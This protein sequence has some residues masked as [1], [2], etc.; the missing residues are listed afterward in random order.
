V[1]DE[2]E[3]L[4]RLRLLVDSGPDGPAAPGATRSVLS[5]DVYVFIPTA[6]PAAAAAGSSSRPEQDSD[7]PFHP[8]AQPRSSPAAAAAR[9]GGGG[10]MPEPV[11]AEEAARAVSDLIRRLGVCTP[12]LL[13]KPLC[14][15]TLPC[16]HTLSVTCHLCPLPSPFLWRNLSVVIFMIRFAPACPRMCTLIRWWGIV[17]TA[18]CV[19]G[20]RTA[21]CHHFISQEPP[22][23]WHSWFLL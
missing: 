7:S 20:A 16:T 10:S 17:L 15:A 9:S 8:A 1:S 3:G 22:Q 21:Y 11:G 6:D 14:F 19:T 13:K 12:S 18:P 2:E 23:V 5:S 4:S